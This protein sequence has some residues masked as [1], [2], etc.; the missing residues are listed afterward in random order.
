M[1]GVVK[2]GNISTENV[3]Y[4]P[5]NEKVKVSFKLIQISGLL[6]NSF[7]CVSRLESKNEPAI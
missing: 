3:I 2:N 6:I 7:K 5:P 4:S 1:Q